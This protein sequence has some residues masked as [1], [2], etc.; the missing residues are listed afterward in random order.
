MEIKSERAC[1]ENEGAARWIV[2]TVG[3]PAGRVSRVTTKWS[4]SD[5]FEHFRCRVGSFR[6]RYA[7]APGLYAVGQP[8]PRS[9]V[10][11][12]A[13]Y[14]LSFDNLRRALHGIDAWVL[15]LDTRGVNVWCA[16]GKGTFGTEELVRRIDAVALE[17]VVA[18][19]RVIVPQLGA[20]GVSA[21]EVQGATRFRVHFGPVRASDIAAYLRAGLEATAEMRRVRF[22]LRERAVLLPMELVPAM[23][24]L[25]AYAALIL[26]LFGVGPHGVRLEEVWSAGVPIAGLG[27]V[28]V[29]SGAVVTPLMLPVVPGRAFAIKGGI[30]GLALTAGYAALVPA[31]HGNGL[32]LAAFAY[33]FAPAASSYLALQFTGSTTFTSMSGVRKELRYSVPIHLAAAA[34]AVALLAAHEVATWSGA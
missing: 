19:R 5:R 26:M 4:S 7:V 32:A 25:A 20:P 30:V 24:A 11:V 21:H 16:A 23:K 1:S 27:V 14:K 15:V 3:T 29:I 33:V 13:N 18:H 17:R 34:I 12:T 6:N 22:G 31:I 8:G 9:E 28:A 2:G 10:L